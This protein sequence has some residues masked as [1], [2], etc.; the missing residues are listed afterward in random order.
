MKIKILITEVMHDKG[1]KLLLNDKNF[2]VDINYKLSNSELASCIRNYDGLIVKTLTKVNKTVID[3]G[4]NL[5]IIG[6]IGVGVDNIDVLYAWK[7]DIKIVNSPH[8]NTIPTAE[9]TIG[10]MLHLAKR[11]DFGHNEVLSGR[12]NRD[13]YRSISLYGKTIGIIGLGRIG[14]AVAKRCSSFGMTVLAYDPYIPANDFRIVDAIK[15]SFDN[16]IKTSDFITLH[17]PLTDETEEM[18]NSSV[19]NR[20][21]EG[22]ILLNCSRGKVI[23][24]DDIATALRTNR[25]ASAGIDVYQVE[26]PIESPLLKVKN[27]LL[28]PHIA[29]Y[30]PEAKAETSEELAQ[31]FIDFFSKGLIKNEVSYMDLGIVK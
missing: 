9:H 22:V 4:E 25:I 19:I 3:A 13:T 27:C 16:L 6:R 14:K 8:G 23:N 17:V 29:S 15:T 7:N 10:M 11:F 18:I 26:P 30:T 28:T 5:R 24:E 31:T 1:L 20:M 21:K 12:W 2:S